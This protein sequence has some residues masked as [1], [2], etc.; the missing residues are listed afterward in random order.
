MV[1]ESGYGIRAVTPGKERHWHMSAGEIDTLVLT[2]P[3][4]TIPALP[5]SGVTNSRFKRKEKR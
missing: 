4:S 5:N 3:G 1:L 2:R